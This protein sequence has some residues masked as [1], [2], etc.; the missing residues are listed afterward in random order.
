MCRRLWSGLFRAFTLIELLV[1]IAIIAILA[2]LLLPALAAAREKARRASCMNNLKQI[3]IALESYCSDYNGHFPSWTGVGVS[4]DESWFKNFPD[5]NRQCASNVTSG[6]CGF[7]SGFYHANGE[8]SWKYLW[9][10]NA[11]YKGSPGDTPVGV[12]SEWLSYYRVIGYGKT[13]T[14]LDEPGLKHAPHGLGYLLATGYMGNA[15]SYYCASSGG[16][17]VNPAAGPGL[18][19][20]GGYR[21]ADWKTAGGFDAKTMQ[22]G[23]W[24]TYG[25]GWSG[26]TIL[27]SHYA[28]RN[29]P[30]QHKQAWHTYAEDQRDLRTALAFTKPA[31]FLKYGAPNFRTQKQLGGRSIVS[32][33]FDK[34]FQFSRYVDALGN[35]YPDAPDS[36]GMAGMGITAHRD[37]YNVL[38]GDGH[39]KWLGDPQ[40]RL[41]WFDQG[42]QPANGTQEPRNC[43]ST[44]FWYGAFGPYAIKSDGTTA[45]TAD[46]VLWTESSAS[47][48]HDFDVDAGVDV[49]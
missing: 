21:L 19:K 15:K 18:G 4:E 44:N 39:A 9:K 8:N 11:D 47:V 31:Q 42:A 45:M 28:Y 13:T 36:V 24:K 5:A 16:G 41:I 20:S 49:F 32:D 26:E 35:P 40:Q 22:Y 38:Y 23:K 14:G 1:V 25:W 43:L 12:G 33:G 7:G 30:L 34:T 46:D 3:A 17:A 48:W 6:D 29:V 27:W 2:A 37:G 10:W